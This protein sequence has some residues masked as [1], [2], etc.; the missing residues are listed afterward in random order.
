MVLLGIGCAE[1][2]VCVIDPRVCDVVGGGGQGNGGGG[3]GGGGEGGEGGGI[4]ADCAP[5][6]GL[7]VGA[8]C[9]VFVQAGATGGDGSQASPYG[10]LVE[11]LQNEP[12]AARVYVC[13]GDTFEGSVEVSAGTSLFGGFACESWTYRRGG[14]RPLIL[15]DADVPAMRIT[16]AGSSRVMSLD[17][18]APS[19]EAAGASSLGLWVSEATVELEAVGITAGDGAAGAAPPAQV[20]QLAR[21]QGGMTGAVAGTVP[22]NAMGG[23]NTCG[24]VAL[25]GGA[26]GAGGLMPN[27]NGGDGNAGEGGDGGTLGD[28]QTGSPCTDGGNGG[29]GSNGN[30]G[31]GATSLGFA[32]ADGFTAADGEPGEAGT[33]GHSGGGGGGSRASASSHGAGGGGGGAGGCGG[34]AG[35]AGRGGGSS[36]GIVSLNATLTLGDGVTVTVGS[37]GAGGAGGMGQFGQLGGPLGPGGTGGGGISS[38]CSGGAGGD[39]GA[40]GNGGGGR[41]GHAIGIAYVGAE[42]AGGTVDVSGSTEGVGGPGGD[43]GLEPGGAGADGVVEERLEL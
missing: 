17:L 33:Y 16:G 43:N 23:A 6:E 37:G 8:S 12:S 13:G 1:T 24:L 18:E 27:G 22:V 9:G 4:S 10:S 26:G 42:P 5:T 28:G 38:A 25:S 29:L 2:D 3:P 11:A 7:A 35:A 41:G 34:E 14:A 20:E 15:G 19:A 36:L 21:A 39:G 32:D 30:P 40:G 31:L